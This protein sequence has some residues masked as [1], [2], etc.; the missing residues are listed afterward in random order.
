M[1]RKTARLQSLKRKFSQVD[2]EPAAPPACESA[3][4]KQCSKLPGKREQTDPRFHIKAFFAEYPTFNYRSSEP[5]MG[6]FYRMCDMFQWD[7]DDEERQEARDKIKDALAQQFNDIYGTDV[8]DLASWQNLCSVLNLS[9]V[10]EEIGPCRRLV[11][12]LY[13]N[14]VDL[15]DTPIT[16]KPVV[17]FESEVALSEYTKSTGKFFPRDS[18]RAGDLLEYLLRQIMT[19]GNGKYRPQ[20]ANQSKKKKKP[21][22]RPSNAKRR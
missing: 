8:N 10:P 6:E 2:Q 19:P 18:V 1:G 9:N 4:K 22:T 15:V 5:V 16:Q 21:R 3:P 17:H 11:K 13:V 7:R 20:G 12:S 14:M